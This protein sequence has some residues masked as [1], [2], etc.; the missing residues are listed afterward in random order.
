MPRTFGLEVA[1]RKEPTSSTSAPSRAWDEASFDAALLADRGEAAVSIAKDLREWA[2]QPAI[3]LEV[4]YGRGAVYGTVALG[5]GD[6]SGKRRSLVS[7][8]TIGYAQLDLGN[9]QFFPA[10]A[11]YEARLGVLRALAP[12]EGQVRKDTQADGW[13]QFDTAILRE[14]AS[15]AAFKALLTDLVN[16]ARLG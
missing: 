1:E 4:W 2:V 13:P 10:F 6:P 9:L 16:R 11:E 8:A 3:G 15:L 14:P 5:L 7:L 12:I